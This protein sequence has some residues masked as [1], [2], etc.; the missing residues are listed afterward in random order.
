MF[1]LSQLRAIGMG[2]GPALSR[3]DMR[4]EAKGFEKFLCRKPLNKTG[5]LQPALSAIL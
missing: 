3:L 4:D 1:F 5:Y 2:N